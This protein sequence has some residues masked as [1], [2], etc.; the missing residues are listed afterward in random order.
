MKSDYFRVM[1]SCPVL[2]VGNIE[3]NYHSICEA[4]DQ[5]TNDKCDMLVL[6]RLALTSTDCKDFLYHDTIL[7]TAQQYLK[8]L[9][10]YTTKLDTI[11]LV[12][13]PILFCNEILQVV[14]V[15]LKGNL[16]GLSVNTDKDDNRYINICQNT[17][18]IGNNIYTLNGQYS[19]AIISG[20][21][22][23]DTYQSTLKFCKLGV[24][25]VI[26]IQSNFAQAYS[27]IN[28]V[29]SLASLSNATK[30]AIV[31]ISNNPLDSAYGFCYSGDKIVCEAGQT[32]ANGTLDSQPIVAD[33]DLRYI[34]H[35]NKTS[36]KSNDISPILIN[37]NTIKTSEL[38]RIF[39]KNPFVADESQNEHILDILTYGVYTKMQELNTDK[40]IFGLS[41]GLDSTMVLLIAN[42]VCKK[43][44]IP[45]KNILAVSMCGLGTGSKS[46]HNTKILTNEF[47]T[48]HILIDISKAVTQHLKD[49][50]HNKIDTTY[51]NA[52]ARER[53]KTLLN[54]SNKYGALLLGTGDLSEIALGWSTYG[55]DQLAQFNPNSGLAKSQIRALV[56]YIAN[57][58]KNKNIQN[59]LND[60]LNAPISPEL[61]KDQDTEQILGPYQLHDFFL[62]HFVSRGCSITQTYLLSVSTFKDIQK[63]DIKKYLETFVTRFFKNQF[64]RKY[65]CD[66][67]QIFDFDLTDT[68]LNSNFDPSIFVK[69]LKSLD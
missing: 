47:G 50:E 8:K 19:F 30:T 61:I 17:A 9:L 64:K 51:E 27:N 52:Q 12:S 11:I 44:G 29:Q 46:Q 56:K 6:P 16:V 69:E 58:H 57:N 26:N 10:D 62:Y 5:A 60:I 54:L 36:A 49:I 14:A 42:R 15:I 13:L 48:T 40:V 63:R 65:A 4:I 28:T 1:L 21:N 68:K 66:G 43:F 2:K 67:I 25:L 23:N 34:K 24:H 3:H 32:L 20:S 33:I 18:P 31:H 7:D 39:D 38:I 22:D 59:C 35:I 53:A 41:G 45:A 37:K 55:G